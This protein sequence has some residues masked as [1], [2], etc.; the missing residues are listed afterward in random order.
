MDTT[1]CQSREDV[2]SLP[3]VATSS[4]TDRT[5]CW[6]STKCLCSSVPML[7][8]LNPQ[9]P[10][11]TNAL[12]HFCLEILKDIFVC[13]KFTVALRKFLTLIRR[14]SRT[15]GRPLIRGAERAVN[16]ASAQPHWRSLSLRADFYRSATIASFLLHLVAKRFVTFCA[17]LFIVA[18]RVF[19]R[20]RQDYQIYG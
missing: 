4:I 13:K 15:D 14:P 1:S 6:L 20:T 10:R 19:S 8:S 7:V 5:F 3:S 2:S 9:N 18:Y 12:I 17:L 11:P 16:S